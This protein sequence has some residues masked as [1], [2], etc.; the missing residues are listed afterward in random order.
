LNVTNG[1][2]VAG[3]LQDG[4]VSGEVLPWN[5]L[6]HEGPVP[7]GLSLEEMSGMRARFL[8]GALEERSFDEVAAGLLRR[9]KALKAFKRHEEVTLW[10]AHHLHDQ[11]QLCQVLHWFSQRELGRTGLSLICIDRHPD[12]ERFLGLGQLSPDQLAALDGER[13]PVTREL[14]DLATRAW[15]AFCSERPTGLAALA[16]EELAPLPFLRA[17]L[18]RHLEQLP[19]TRD[20]LSRTER[21]IA[22]AVVRK[23]ATLSEVFRVSQVER[24]PHP[25]MA[26]RAFLLNLRTICGGR[27]NVVR[28]TEG[29]GLAGLVLA[30]T[31]GQFWDRKLQLTEIGRKILAGQ[32]DHVRLYGIDRWLG[33]VHLRGSHAAW[34]WDDRRGAVIALSA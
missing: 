14:L 18:A 5:D 27:S 6:L 21:Q 19:W 12:V 23:P 15:E 1:D 2:A 30:P 25:Y 10:F 8:A 32:A 9:D 24:E 28:F 7:A 16:G 4:G 34:R 33:G 13:R 20:G 29:E 3:L 31:D 26:D 22:E 17:A 11:L